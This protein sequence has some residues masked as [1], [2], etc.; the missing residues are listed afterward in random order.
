MKYSD[1]GAALLVLSVLVLAET[2]TGKAADLENFAATSAAPLGSDERPLRRP[3]PYI[4]IEQWSGGRLKV[5]RVPN[6]DYDATAFDLSPPRDQPSS[7]PSTRLER[8][9][10]DSSQPLNLS[11]EAA[12]GADSSLRKPDVFANHPQVDADGVRHFSNG[13]H[14]DLSKMAVDTAVDMAKSSD[15]NINKLNPG[16]GNPL[17]RGINNSYLPATALSE[18]LDKNSGQFSY[19]SAW[20][21]SSQFDHSPQQ[22]QWQRRRALRHARRLARMIQNF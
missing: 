18:G 1:F 21:S 2:A 3:Q 22:N 10:L 6:P 8:N 17:R 20:P 13:K 15:S 19:N 11:R 16:S 14:F 5:K 4:Q 9:F 7:Y 12:A